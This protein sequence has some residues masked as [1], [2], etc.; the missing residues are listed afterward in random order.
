MLSASLWPGWWQQASSTEGVGAWKGG[1]P[2]SFW[3]SRADGTH[4]AGSVLLP[5]PMLRPR[6]CCIALEAF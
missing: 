5:P 6:F 4:R 3:Q 1:C 2:P